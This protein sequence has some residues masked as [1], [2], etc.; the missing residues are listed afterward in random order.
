MVIASIGI[1]SGT[2]TKKPPRH[3]A[4]GVGYALSASQLLVPAPPV[5]HRLTCLPV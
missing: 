3:Y 2:Y 4:E 1:Y 5:V